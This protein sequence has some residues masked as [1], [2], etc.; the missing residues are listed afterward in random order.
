MTYQEGIY[1]RPLPLGVLKT[2]PDFRGKSRSDAPGRHRISRSLR[3]FADGSRSGMTTALV[4]L[5]G[6]CWKPDYRAAAGARYQDI[7]R[8]TI[9]CRAISSL[10]SA[11]PGP[12]CRKDF[13]PI[14]SFTARANFADDSDKGR[15]KFRRSILPA[16]S[17]SRSWSRSSAPAFLFMQ[18]Q[19][20]Q[21]EE[22]GSRQFHILWSDQGS[23]GASPCLGGCQARF[24]FLQP[25][26]SADLRYGGTLL[27]ATRLG[28][29][30]SSQYPTWPKV[31]AC[32][33]RLVSETSFV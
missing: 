3:C 15:R 30:G 6:P 10:I 22:L 23:R 29:A 24:R 9:E 21:D 20:F 28:S 17:M 26:L 8:G 2:L 16:L 4:L 13:P 1:L 19:L 31:S 18:A 27:P 33:G 7:D 11:S 12:K 32:P 25:A 5:R 14:S